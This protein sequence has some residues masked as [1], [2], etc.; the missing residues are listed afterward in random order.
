MIRIL[1]RVWFVLGI[2]AL[3]YIALQDANLAQ[4]ATLVVLLV[5]VA[6][7]LVLRWQPPD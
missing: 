1:V 3:L 4:R 7:A 2:M 6:L 5:L